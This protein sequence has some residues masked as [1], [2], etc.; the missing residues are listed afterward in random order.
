MIERLVGGFGVCFLGDWSGII[1]IV[2]KL[3]FGRYKR[4]RR[5][6]KGGNGWR[7]VLLRVVLEDDFFKLG[8]KKLNDGV[9]LWKGSNEDDGFEDD[10]MTVLFPIGV[11]DLA[12][13]MLDGV[14]GRTSC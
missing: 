9:I 7:A 1:E 8:R 10:G 3:S 13:P 4:R 14:G 6:R 5:R 2:G 11:G 12:L